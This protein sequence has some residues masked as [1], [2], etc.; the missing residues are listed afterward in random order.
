LKSPPTLAANSDNNGPKHLAFAE[1]LGMKSHC[2]NRIPRVC[3]TDGF[4]LYIC[5]GINNTYYMTNHVYKAEDY[6]N[7]LLFQFC[8]LK[9]TD[10]QNVINGSTIT[11]YDELFDD[12]N[13]NIVEENNRGGNKPNKNA[14]SSTS[15]NRKRKKDNT[16]DTLP[17]IDFKYYDAVEEHQNKIA[18]VMK[19]ENDIWGH[20][21]LDKEN[22]K[23]NNRRHTDKEDNFVMSK[24]L[25]DIKLISEY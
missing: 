25:K 17:E 22:L 6:L 15:V 9:R 16:S 1:L 23:E 20:G 2:R 19:L 8:D 14:S 4:A 7:I 21:N 5:F 11:E 18:Y 13:N 24:F 12:N 10:L 3:L